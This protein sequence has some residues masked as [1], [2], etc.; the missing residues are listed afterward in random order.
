D[1]VFPVTTLELLSGSHPSR[2]SPV[3]AVLLLLIG[4][5]LA[6]SEPGPSARRLVQTC[7]AA[8]L[9]I[10]IFLAIGLA[11]GL[12]E[13]TQIVPFRNVSLPTALVTVLL[14]SGMLSSR[15]ADGFMADFTDTAAGGM[16]ARRLLPW[17]VLVPFVLG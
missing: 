16:L 1:R 9:V 17:A 15:P 10:A 7:A 8:A 2:M 11:F 6:L 12:F 5:G 13:V 14:A 4:S 3:S